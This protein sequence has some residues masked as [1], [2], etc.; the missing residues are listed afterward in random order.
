M[1]VL[2]AI[3]GTGNEHL[4]LAKSVIPCLLSRGIELDILVSGTQS[5]IDIPYKTTYRYKGL[6]FIFGKKGGIDMW[7]TYLKSNASRLKAEIDSLPIETYDLV[8]NDFEPISA[9]AA[10][11]KGVPC[12]SFSH[13]IAVMD[14]KAPKPKNSN[15]MGQLILKNYAPSNQYFG[16]HFKAYS[17]KMFTPI[18]RDKIRNATVGNKGHYTVYLPSYSD[19]KLLKF[20]SKIEG[21]NWHIFSKHCVAET[22]LD[23]IRLMPVSNDQ[24][25]DSLLSSKGVLC[26]AGFE[27]PAEAL[28]LKKKLMVIPMKGQYEQQC[29]AA[30]LKK[31]GVSVLKSLKEKHILKVQQW[32]LNDTLIPVSYPNQTEEIIDEI[33]EWGLVEK[34]RKD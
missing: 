18:I 5:D 14:D 22:A 32:I 25:V 34:F 19:K 28:F 4:S 6:S 29:N 7:R 31:M 17:S 23:Q 30:A 16:L 3:Q 1:K 13:Q 24:F 2:Y 27:T 21:V 20:F 10:K 8:I 9:W 26:G 12:A 11:I 33:I 15:L